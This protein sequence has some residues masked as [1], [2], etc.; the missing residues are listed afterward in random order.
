MPGSCGTHVSTSTDG[1][2]HRLQE[3]GGVEDVVLSDTRHSLPL[4]PCCR[5]L[6]SGRLIVKRDELQARLEILRLKQ[7][8]V[9]LLT[10]A[11]FSCA[12]SPRPPALA[13]GPPYTFLS[14]LCS[15]A[16]TCLLFLAS[17][18]VML[19]R[20]CAFSAAAPPSSRCATIPNCAFSGLLSLS[21][22]LLRL[23]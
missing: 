3:A 10:R 23:S 22:P 14:S 12:S 16:Y 2:L 15:P 4:T 13:F 18:A 5:A 1:R 7:A 6:V 20:D 11:S 8:S 17:S 9:P 19:G 21:L